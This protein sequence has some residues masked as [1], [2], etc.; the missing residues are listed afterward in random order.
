MR[1]RI[2]SL[3]IVLAFSCMPLA[4]QTFVLMTGDS[5]LDITL[6]SLN[7]EARSD[8]GSFTT[9]LSVTFQV[10]QTQI[11]SWITVERLQPAEIYLVLELARISRKPPATVIVVY[12]K[13]RGRGWGVVA[14][15]LGIRPGSAEFREWKADAD[16]RD[17][18]VKARR[19]RNFPG[20][21]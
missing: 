7:V 2:V 4:A 8:M 14:R 6:S 5:G 1:K 17:R 15:E 11:Q 20:G 16:D 13:Y 18:F 12:R 3:G 21:R 10:R 19:Q 9:E